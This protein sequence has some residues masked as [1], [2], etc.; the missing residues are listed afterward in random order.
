M[1]VYPDEVKVT[2]VLSVDP[3][4]LFYTPHGRLGIRLFSEDGFKFLTM[5]DDHL[6]VQSL[7]HAAISHLAV[8]LGANLAVELPK[9]SQSAGASVGREDFT[10]LASV[11]KSGVTLFARV[12]LS[13]GSYKVVEVSLEDFT[14]SENLDSVA[15]VVFE[16]WALLA[17][18]QTHGDKGEIVWGRG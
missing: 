9:T 11:N 14:F 7:P 3:G 2:S 13:H 17:E 16:S 10:D 6:E 18:F 4:T 1:K 15:R 12:D 5:T 8:I